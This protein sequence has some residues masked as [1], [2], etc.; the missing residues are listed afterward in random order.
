MNLEIDFGLNELLW[1]YYLAIGIERLFYKILCYYLNYILII[2]KE[3][4]LGIKYEQTNVVN[5]EICGNVFFQGRVVEWQR[6]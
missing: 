4:L 6:T 1:C 5:I 3:K 2:G